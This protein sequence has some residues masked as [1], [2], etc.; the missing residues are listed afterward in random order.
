MIRARVLFSRFVRDR[1]GNIAMMFGL[2]LFVILAAAGVAIDMQRSSLFRAE[3]HEASDAALLAAARY[4]SAHPNADDSEL[5]AVAR[6]VFDSGVRDDP[7]I[8]IKGFQVIFDNAGGAFSLDVVGDVNT[9]IMD[10]FGQSYVDIST[11]AEAKLGKTPLLEVAMALDVTGSM[12][13][14]GKISTMRN[15]ARDLVKSLFE[16]DAANV[17]VGV[18]PFAQYANI[19]PAQG[20]ASWL[21]NPGIAWTGCVGSRDYPYNTLDSDY[22]AN[23]IPGLL[24]APCPGELMPLSNDAD[25]LDK[26]I[27]DLMPNGWTYIPAGLTWA[28]NLLTPTEPFS[29]GVSFEA[30]DDHHGVKA[31]ILM[32]DGE[33]TRAPDYPTHNSADQM[34]ANDLTEEI[35]VNIKKQKIIVYTIAF[36]V[37][38]PDIKDILQGCATTPS[39]FFDAA[40][41]SDL[42]DAFAAIGSSL[43][44]ISLS[45]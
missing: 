14:K 3:I 28:W 31:L 44:T 36:D 9:L 25:A 38:D 27:G 1:R 21:S 6:K 5:T 13:Q 10:I 18:V 41:A 40:S 35:C 30:L 12:N 2:F 20:A 26:M 11:R 34:L 22:V 15:A 39:H 37:S 29:E 8:N 7:A 33:N 16:F 32:T 23:K 24:G 4:K 45:K 42:I 19:G 17:K 43:R